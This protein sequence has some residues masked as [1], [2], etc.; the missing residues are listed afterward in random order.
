V[1]LSPVA[2]VA[3][4]QV[5]RSR[6]KPGPAGARVYGP[7]P[8]LEVDALDVGPRGVVG[9]TADGPVPD[10]HHADHPDTRNRRLTNGLSLLPRAHY[11]SLRARYG[12]H[13]ADGVAGESLLLDTEA[14]W[15]EA[16]VEGTLWLETADGRLLELGGAVA[17]PPCVEFSRFC[18][19]LPLGPVGPDVSQALLDLDGGARGF[20]AE[21]RDTGRVERGA[22][23]L[24]G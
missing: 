24:R 21:V 8:L 5:Q 6:L 2:T 22:R 19:Q 16:D 4:L 20:Y 13:L 10:V 3:R 17:A 9:Q 23:L 7:E 15:T 18:L 11:A 14:P 1:A 12:P